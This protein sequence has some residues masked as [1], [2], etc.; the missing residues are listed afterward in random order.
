MRSC[1]A[2]QTHP[3]LPSAL[4]AGQQLRQATRRCRDQLQPGTPQLLTERRDVGYP[5][6]P[7][8]TALQPGS[9]LWLP[10]RSNAL[11]A[12]V[13]F[14]PLKGIFHLAAQQEMSQSVTQ[15][16]DTTKHCI[17]FYSTQIAMFVWTCLLSSKK[18]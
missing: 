16:S 9:R 7:Q 15:I 8:H 3:W 10:A 18:K 11:Q 17:H 13:G 6:F 5:A 1:E 14:G 2:N 12:N 4:P